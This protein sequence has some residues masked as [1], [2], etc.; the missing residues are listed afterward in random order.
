MGI[1]TITSDWKNQDFYSGMLKGRLYMHLPDIKIVDINHQIRPFG[2]LEG[3]FIARNVFLSFPVG[4]INLFLINQGNQ[5]GVY[6]LLIRAEDR[7]LIAWEDSVLGLIFDNTPEWCIRI[8]PEIF[9]KVKEITRRNEIRVSPSFPELDIFPVL[10]SALASG[11][12]FRELGSNQLDLITQSPWLPVIQDQTITGRVLL[13]DSYGNAIS[14]ISRTLF[15]Q[16]IQGRRFE[17]FLISNHY[18]IDRL[19]TGYLETEP[20]EMLALF[21]SVGF[22]EVAIVHG[23]IA[24]LLGLEPGSTIKIKF[25]D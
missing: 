6:P 13:I 12:N 15:E 1:V 2:T 20:G 18:K 23:S 24:S 5:P 8:S 25:Y 14:N 10:V 4:T 16:V 19:N 21:N 11:V 22:L 17:I 9:S 3:A 7:Y